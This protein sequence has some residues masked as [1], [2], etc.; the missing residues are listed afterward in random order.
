MKELEE[1]ILEDGTVLPGSILKVDSF[2]NHQVDTELMGHIAD[3]FKGMYEQ[4]KITKVLTIEAS[5]I[6]IAVMTANALKVP[7]LFAKKAKS[8]N[9]GSDVYT[10]SVHSYTYGREYDITVSRKYLN[11]ND[12]VLIVD[13]FMANGLAAQGLIDICHQAHAEIAG[14]GICIE[15]G[16]QDGGRKLREQGY[17]VESLALIDQMTDNS[18]TFR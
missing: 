6:A 16:F 4:E 15:K 11:E 9:I 13:D 5:G 14:F 10:A 1:R 8:S 18:I 7:A 12:R 3:E 17:R 2:L